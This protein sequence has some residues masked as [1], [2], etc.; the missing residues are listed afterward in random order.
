AAFFH[1]LALEKSGQPEQALQAYLAA[2]ADDVY[3]A[4]AL[5]KAL[6]LLANYPEEKRA[7]AAMIGDEVLSAFETAI[8]G[9]RG[10]DPPVTYDAYRRFTPLAFARPEEYASAGGRF[11]LLILWHDRQAPAADP[12]AVFLHVSEVG[13][14]LLVQ[15]GADIFLQLQWVENQVLWDGVEQAAEGEEVPG[16]IDTARDWFG[17]RSEYAPVVR[18]D[19]TGNS[20]LSL[21]KVTWLGSV[22]VPAREGAGYLFAGR[23]RARSG[24][25]G[26]TWQAY[27]DTGRVL[28]ED[29]IAAEGATPDAWTWHAGYR[30][31]Q[32]PWDS[33]RVQLSVLPRAGGADFDDLM[34]VE[35]QEPDPPPLT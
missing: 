29:D 32:L 35:V 12:G 7:A 31:S 27:D 18:K 33:L 8:A 15:P 24:S 3:Y 23:V 16:W 20:F 30:A 19:D 22:P 1:G 4:F 9:L 11:P 34:L 13:D 21:P 17:L 26:M 10:Q 28:F 2:K 25:A 5:T 6:T 14:G